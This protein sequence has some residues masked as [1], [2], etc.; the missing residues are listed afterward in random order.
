MS[1]FGRL[2]NAG[3]DVD[4]PGGLIQFDR[5]VMFN[6]GAFTNIGTGKCFFLDYANGSDSNAGKTPTQAVKTL[7]RAQAIM[8]ANQNDTLY[9]IDNGTA[10]TEATQFTWSKDGC[11]IIGVGGLKGVIN[12]GVTITFTNATAGGQFILSADKCM[13][14][15]IQFNH[16]PSNATGVVSVKVTGDYDTFIDCQFLN[17]NNAASAGAAGYLGLSL[18]GCNYPSFIRCTVGGTITLRTVSAADLT[19]GAGT[20]LGLSMVDCIFIADLDATAD[21]NHAFI[22]VIADADLGDLVLLDRCTFINAGALAAVPDAITVGATATGFI[23][24]RD[25]LLVYITDIADNEEK[26]WVSSYRDT[27]PGKFEGIA[28]NTD[29]T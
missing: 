5:Q 24:L 13:I 15:N 27:T 7:T 3:I 28:V 19:I 20:I 6:Q 14:V 25:P 1:D 4:G 18:D 23:L 29:V 8:T 16:T 2:L 10:V 26:V 17:A 21:A 12:K 9:I 22:E 11:N